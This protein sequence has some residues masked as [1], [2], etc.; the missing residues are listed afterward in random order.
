MRILIWD[1]WHHEVHG[2]R[3]V[4]V[5]NLIVGLL[6]RG[7]DVALV[8]DKSSPHSYCRLQSSPEELTKFELAES[9]LFFDS[10]IFA[11]L[12]RVLIFFKYFKPDLIHSQSLTCPSRRLLDFVNTR[13]ELPFPEILTIH[14]IYEAQKLFEVA[15]NPDE[16]QSLNSIAVPSEYLYDRLARMEKHRNIELV[17]HGITKNVENQNNSE[18]RIIYSG[19]LVAEK[20]VI[21]LVL[22]FSKVFQNSFNINLHIFGDGNLRTYLERLVVDLH[23]SE[24]VLFHGTKSNVEVREFLNSESILVQPSLI[25]EAF[26][27]SVLEAMSCSSG[28]IVSDKGNLPYLIRNGVDGMV[29]SARDINALARHMRNLASNHTLRRR[30]GNSAQIRAIE[31]FSSEQMI[32]QYEKLYFQCLL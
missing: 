10:R 20:G 17:P 30:L 12:R 5:D 7:H 18:T 14:N 8:S 26:G 27:L 16:L 1:Y 29:Y 13:F 2:G 28:I 11:E 32:D 19:R 24:R 4:F 23:L 15:S 3:Q 31:E 22:A 9:D 25:P 6:S 21:D